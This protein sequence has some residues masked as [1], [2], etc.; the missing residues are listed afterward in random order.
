MKNITQIDLKT[1]NERYYIKDWMIYNKNTNSNNSKKDEIAGWKRS[2]GFYVS[3]NKKSY[4]IHRIIY[5][6]I[7]N[8]EL[9]PSDKVIDHIDGNPYNNNISN[10]RLITQ[11]QNSKNTSGHKDNKL[12]IKGI[13]YNK[14][15]KKYQAQ[16][17]CDG[18][19]YSKRFDALEKAK[20]WYDEQSKILFGI[21]NR[22]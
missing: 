10:L 14:A 8:I 17:M 6:M 11:S 20:Y 3:I 21:Y 13:T 5:Q 18:I 12:G 4:A 2:G 22:T 9:L 19:K 15:R 1:L 16:I 7:N